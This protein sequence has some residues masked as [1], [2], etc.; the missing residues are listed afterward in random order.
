MTVTEESSSGYVLDERMKTQQ[1]RRGSIES[2]DDTSR[3]VSTGSPS[4]AKRRLAPAAGSAAPA[5][6]TPPPQN[7]RGHREGRRER[8][9]QKYSGSTAQQVVRRL[10]E[11]DVINRGM[12]F[13]AVL[14]LC[15]FP[16]LIVLDA[17][18]GRDAVNGLARHLG[19]NRE[20]ASYVRNLFAPSSSTAS[21]ITA[22]GY[23]LFIV[24]GIAGAT[25]IQDLYE[26]V[27]DLTRRG[28]KD[29]PRRLLW[30]GVAVAGA[31]L[32]DWAGPH[33]RSSGGP[34]LFGVIAL[35]ALTVFWWFTMW[36]L[37][38]G[39][40][41]WGELFPAAVATASFWIGMQIVFSFT[42]SDMVISN[43]KK[44]GP[45]GVVFSLM[46]WLIAIGVVIILGALVGVVW[47]ER[48]LSFSAA[49]GRLRSRAPAK[50]G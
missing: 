8:V 17:L 3:D 11:I 25:A 39:R 41:P 38:A 36:F 37:L 5:G 24:G 9:K 2:V 15:F 48:G 26:R 46:S 22:T 29:T 31:L 19:L 44:Y 42:F 35:A 27:F 28:M 18:A 6:P 43:Q 33:L 13:A 47:R 30:L 1:P 21:A 40:V 32:V 14:F 49:L 7:G 34:V 10:G 23:V 16:F 50:R 20:A 45:I 12:L 4:T